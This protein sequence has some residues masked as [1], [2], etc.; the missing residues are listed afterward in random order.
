MTQI[1]FEDLFTISKLKSNDT[2]LAN[3]KEAG[4]GD[5]GITSLTPTAPET[6]LPHLDI[7][8]ALIGQGLTRYGNLVAYVFLESYMRG[9]ESISFGRDKLKIAALRLNMPVPENLADVTFAFR[10]RTPLPHIISRTAPN[11]FEWR[12][13]LAG[14]AKYEFVLRAINNLEAN[15]DLAGVELQDATP[16]FL[17]EMIVG[18]A[19]RI[20]TL[21]KNNGLISK[22]LNTEAEHVQSHL[23][24]TVAGTGQIEIGSLFS[25]C[26]KATTRTIV[27]V[28]LQTEPGPIN[29]TKVQQNMRY[30]ASK[31]PDMQCRA[32]VAQMVAHETL[33]LFEIGYDDK[34]FSVLKEQKYLLK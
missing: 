14:R 3:S 34:M 25:E 21:I 11:G 4:L 30:A 12:I 17:K 10:N 9:K 1:I 32:L 20:D 2:I 19:A 15:L 29:T 23:R 16:I 28:H 5:S 18:P 6:P 8:R 26:S 7:L 27:P 22:F 33:V 13:E 24:S 31:H